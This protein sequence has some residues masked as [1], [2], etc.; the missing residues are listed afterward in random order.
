[1]KQGTPS[2]VSEKASEHPWIQGAPSHL[3]RTLK[4]AVSILRKNNQRVET[5]KD[6]KTPATHNAENNGGLSAGQ[7]PPLQLEPLV[8]RTVPQRVLAQDSPTNKKSARSSSRNADEWSQ[9]SQR[10]SDDDHSSARGMGPRSIIA[11]AKEDVAKN[12]SQEKLSHRS[13]HGARGL[14]SPIQNTGLNR[15]RHGRLVDA[16]VVNS[17]RTHTTSENTSTENVSPRGFSPRTLVHKV[18]TKPREK[19][20]N[21]PSDSEPTPQ[22]LPPPRTSGLPS[23][24]GGSPREVR[25]E[26]IQAASTLQGI[27]G[28]RMGTGWEMQL[29][30]GSKDFLAPLSL[31]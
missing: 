18:S 21:F 6:E 20:S 19:P 12:E 8:Y 27:G 17:S 22:P 14:H 3:L 10:T 24:N 31:R 5:V 2:S 30:E 7:I 9:I 23:N 11:A 13:N 28:S 25:E 4:K 16:P 15:H 29:G 1:M 26:S